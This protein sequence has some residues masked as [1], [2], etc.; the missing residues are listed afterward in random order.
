VQVLRKI[1]AASAAALK[2]SRDALVPLVCGLVQS[3]AGP[4]RM[5]AE[6]TLA[7][8]LRLE[9][10]LDSAQAGPPHWI[11]LRA[12]WTQGQPEQDTITAL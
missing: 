12:C 8:V 11:T 6:A 5:A 10:G 1:A 3:T 2:P 4:T 7:R 9:D